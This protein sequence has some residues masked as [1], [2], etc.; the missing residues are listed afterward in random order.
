MRDALFL[1]VAVKVGTWSD[2][3]VSP[4]RGYH[5]VDDEIRVVVD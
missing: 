2:E 1:D 3:S 5:H 4:S